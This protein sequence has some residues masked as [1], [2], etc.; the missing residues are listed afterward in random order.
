MSCTASGAALVSGIG[1]WRPSACML[2][3]VSRAALYPLV[4]VWYRG[5]LSGYN[6]RKSPCKALCIVLLR[7]RYNCIDDA[8]HAVNA[9]SW[10]YWS[11]AK[12]KA[13]HRVDARQKKSPASVGWVDIIYFFLQG[14]Q[15]RR[16]AFAFLPLSSHIPCGAGQRLCFSILHHTGRR[17]CWKYLLTWF[18]SF[19]GFC[20]FLQYIILQAP[21]T[22]LAK[23]FLPFW[24]GA[25][26]LYG[27]APLKCP[28]GSFA[29]LKQRRKEPEKEQNT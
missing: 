15:G 16:K 8:K 3:S 1:V 21:K 10:L 29:G 20:P 2:F 26:L 17:H 22:G 4:S 6:R 18:S 25:G 9:C 13:P 12:I 14:L 24:A 28:G 27:A 11:M 19:P 7:L 23:I 5:R